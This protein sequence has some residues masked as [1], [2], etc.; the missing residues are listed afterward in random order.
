MT[1]IFPKE[2]AQPWTGKPPN[3]H[4]IGNLPFNVS[5]PLIIKYL[6]DISTQ[7]E[8]WSLGRVQLTLTFQKE[9][10]ERLAAPMLDKQRSRLSIMSQYLCHV[11][12]KYT[13][14][15]RAFTPVPEV[16][17]GLVHFVPKCKPEIQQPFKLVE[18]LVRHVFQ[19]RQKMVKHGL[20]WVYV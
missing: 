6:N 12:H 17:V 13:I 16:D 20:R 9:V 14:P 10:A 4:I 15:G 7:S 8:A 18:K 1:D 2:A 11:Q 3:I 5:T 19:Y